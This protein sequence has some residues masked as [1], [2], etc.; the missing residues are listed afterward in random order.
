M[1]GW[2]DFQGINS[3]YVAE[4]YE[5]YR[6]DPASVDAETR[7][8]FERL[9]PP[10]DAA[11][12]EPGPSVGGPARGL[13]RADVIVGAVNLAQ[14]I[15]RYGHLAAQL[16]P[17]G[18]RPIGDPALDPAT[19]NVTE[20]DLRHLPPT[21][22]KG[23][24]AAGCDT[25]LDV[26]NKLRRIYCS[27]IGYDLSHIFVPEER[28]WLRAAIE[29][30]R[31]RA[32][33]DPLDPAALLE[34]L[35]QVEVLERFLHRSFP[36]KTRFSIEGLDMLVPVLD[37]VIAEAAEAGINHIIIGMA[38]RGRLNVMA[39]VLNKPYEQILAEF[40]D[41]LH[42]KSFHEDMAWTGDVK[43]HMGAHR[44]IRDG[45][46]VDLHISMPPNPSHL[47]AINPVVLGMARAAGT[48]ASSPGSPVFDPAKVLAILI[49]GDAAFP[50]QGIVAET[51]NFCRLTGYGVGGTIHII[52]NNQLGFT[53]TPEDSYST[54]YASGL[55]RGFKMPIVHV[56]ADGAEACVEVARLAYAYRAKFHLDFLIDLVGYRRHGHNEGDEP[57]FT[58]PMMY[59][60]IAQHPTA[61][62][63]WARTLADRGAIDPGHAEQLVQDRMGELQALLQSLKPEEAIVEP[64]P[65][66]APPGTARQAV[67]AVPLEQLRALSES[68]LTLP[69]D[70]TPHR[71]LDKARAKRRHA[72][73]KPDER[74]IEW[75]VAEELALASI[76]AD[77]TPIRMTGEDVE[78]G[79]FSQRHAVL[80]DAKTGRTFVPLQALPQAKAA[81]EIHNT[82]LTENAVVGFEYG[83]SI[84]ACDR[85]VLWEAQY[86]DFVNGAQIIIDEFI[87]SAR[88]KWGQEPSLVL[89]LPHAHEGQGPD[90]ASARPERFLQLAADTN[91]RVANCTT[92]AQFFHLLRR[93]AA[94]LVKD[95]LPLVVLTPKS[96]LR[97]PLV[98]SSPRELAEGRWQPVIDDDALETRRV[99]RRRGTAEGDPTPDGEW[100]AGVR[101]LVLCSGKIAVD[102]MT[103]EQ[104]ASADRVAICR[105]EQLY[106]LPVQ[107]IGEVVSGYPALEE[108]L[109]VQEEPENMGAWDFA[110]PHLQDLLR[111]R[112]PLHAVARPRASSPAEGSAAR[113]ARNQ[114][115]LIERALKDA[116]DGGPASS[117]E[118]RVTVGARE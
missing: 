36:G 20:A 74:V 97:H 99:Q 80:H 53:A 27:T 10:E 19:H 24:A 79:T 62:E 6:R 3:A 26:V 85:L 115:V 102:L 87:V 34:R 88:A 60:R 45:E 17:L 95:P 49:H 82:P 94:V 110:R 105:V 71:K 63:I 11:A 96:L 28:Y 50:G 112:L 68:L 35:T 83:Y 33:Q 41:P 5:R 56:N 77:G 29:E 23:T 84:Q 55:A 69:G 21:L 118:R 111:G 7:E 116:I 32:P 61:R 42:S 100:R 43:Y 2:E 37:E 14:S 91:I 48:D 92:A 59:E 44:A 40:K 101:R 70:F 73:D 47:E 4:L 65:D 109:W 51:L 31:F 78:R 86:G 39:H 117:R 72:F 18:T 15:R 46:E 57:A 9:P 76:L 30:G 58:Q 93:Q 16:D 103:S 12:A 114:Q 108:V 104:R 54:S 66:V 81:F 1:S 8:L 75:A 52:A 64:L 25:A 107:D 89:L 98:A 13:D 106:P 67:T 38:H 22:I 90:H 113:H